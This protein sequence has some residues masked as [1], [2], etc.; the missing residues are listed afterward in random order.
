[1]IFYLVSWLWSEGSTPLCVCESLL[2]AKIVVRE[3]LGAMPQWT[4][5]DT[6]SYA[7]LNIV[8]NGATLQGVMIQQVPKYEVD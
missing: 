8:H 5:D 3:K 4:D 1:M 7:T 6:M 2:S